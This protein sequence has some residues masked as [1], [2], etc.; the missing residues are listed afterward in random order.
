MVCVEIWEGGALAAEMIVFPKT[1]GAVCVDGT[2]GGI[3]WSAAE[4]RVAYAGNATRASIRMAR[5]MAAV[6][7]E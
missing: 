2:F 6:K 7:P 5:F 3:S 4:G 1:H